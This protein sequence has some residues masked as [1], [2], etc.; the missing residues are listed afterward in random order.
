VGDLLT[1]DP[2]STFLP[3]FTIDKPQNAVVH[4]Q[5]SLSLEGQPLP[6]LERQFHPELLAN[7]RLLELEIWR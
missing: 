2:L 6:L 4:V 3:N 5:R 7:V 1:H